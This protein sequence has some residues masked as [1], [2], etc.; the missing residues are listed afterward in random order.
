MLRDK[1]YALENTLEKQVSVTTDL[2]NR[3]VLAVAVSESASVLNLLMVRGGY[4]V[5]SRHFNLTGSLSTEAEMLSAFLRQFYDNNHFIPE[6]ILVPVLPEDAGVFADWLGDIKG[7]RVK[8][9]APRR[10]DKVRLVQMA[11]QNA[12]NR[13]KDLVALQTAEMDIL[14]RL[15]T[16]L[17]MD[18]LPLRIECIDNSNISGRQPVGVIVVFINAKPQK[19][20][21]RKYRLRSVS[22]PDDYAYMAEVLKRRYGKGSDSTPYPDVLLVDG[23]KGQL[24]IAVSVLKAL[25]IE[26]AFKVIGIA[27]K[28]EKKGETADKVYQPGRANPID[29]SRDRDLLFFLQRIRDEAHRFAITFHRNRR[30]ADF[31]ESILDT[32]PGIGKQRKKMLLKHFGSIQKI[33]AAPLEELSRL[34]GINDKIARSIKAKLAG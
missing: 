26:N 20:S 18:H 10:G 27:K 7:A 31:M 33:R 32:V 23:G 29:F 1:M 16:R 25:N 15:Q 12:H 11:F 21:Y 4:L 3:D 34:P 19:S 2:K 17:R 8:I 6:E 30:R 5:G 24:N 14:Q 22:A 28:D 13:L 9:L